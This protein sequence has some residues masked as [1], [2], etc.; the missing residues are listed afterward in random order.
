MNHKEVQERAKKFT[1][2]S[3]EMDDRLAVLANS[4]WDYIGSDMLQCVQESTGK[5]S[6]KRSEVIEVVCDADYMLTNGRG[7][8][9]QETY[10]YYIYLRDN[11]PKYLD[12]LMKKSFPYR[13]YG[14]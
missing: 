1:G 14:W 11:N 2:V 10:A 6:M 12:K 3:K 9:D 13:T 4:T 5:S 7:E 8:K